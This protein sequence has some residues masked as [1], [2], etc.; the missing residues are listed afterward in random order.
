MSGSEL[1]EAL[2]AKL[3][4]ESTEVQNAKTIHEVTEELADVAEVI[5][6]LCKAYGISLDDLAQ[7]KEERRTTRGGFEKGLYINR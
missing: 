6:G 3:I 7:V 5:D 2:K 1:C 4:E